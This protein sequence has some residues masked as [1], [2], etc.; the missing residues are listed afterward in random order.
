M[1]FADI[2]G[3]HSGAHIA[4]V[5]LLYTMACWNDPS[6]RG[7][8][9]SVATLMAAGRSPK[10]GDLAWIAAEYRYV[11]SHPFE[12]GG[13]VEKTQ[14]SGTVGQIEEALGGHPLTDGRAHHAIPGKPA[15]HGRASLRWRGTR[16]CLLG[17]RPSLAAPQLPRRASR[18]LASDS[19]RP[20]RAPGCPRRFPVD[21]PP[22]LRSGMVMSGP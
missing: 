15:R 8:V 18:C 17:S 19:P 20:G 7:I 13:L 6:A 3:A 21:T 9:G 2:G 14:I 16:T 1:A 5:L 12:R 4:S 22:T 11:L 10:N